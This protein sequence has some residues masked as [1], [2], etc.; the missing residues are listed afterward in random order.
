MYHS[1]TYLS[2]RPLRWISKMF[3][4]AFH[5]IYIYVHSALPQSK[6]PWKWG[7]KITRMFLKCFSCGLSSGWQVHPV[8]RPCPNTWGKVHIVLALG[9]SLWTQRAV[10]S[11]CVYGAG[12]LFGGDRRATVQTWPDG[13]I[14]LWWGPGQGTWHKLP[15]LTPRV[16]LN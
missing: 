9:P 13:Q 12:R 10:W 8:L 3:R 7:S 15:P 4:G 16:R 5:I 11:R 14:Y 2:I 1:S 6:E